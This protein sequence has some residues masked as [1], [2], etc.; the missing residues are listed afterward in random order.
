[1]TRRTRDLEHDYPGAEAEK[2]TQIPKRGWLQVV[3][4]AWAES[5]TDQVPLMAAGVAFYSL[6]LIHI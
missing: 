5:K 4:R 2:P 6:S 1:M 3:K